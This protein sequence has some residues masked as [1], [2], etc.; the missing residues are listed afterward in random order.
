MVFPERFEPV[1]FHGMCVDD[2][3]IQQSDKLKSY[4]R[5]NQAKYEQKLSDMRMWNA[6][7]IN[8]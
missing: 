1:L 3:M 8:F 4:A 7:L 5:E 2:Y 6:K